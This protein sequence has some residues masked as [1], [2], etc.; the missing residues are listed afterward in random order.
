MVAHL[1]REEDFLK[2]HI[3]KCREPEDSGNINAPY[4]RPRVKP[5]DH[6]PVALLNHPPL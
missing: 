4:L 1:S 3:K 5:F 2:M 6:F